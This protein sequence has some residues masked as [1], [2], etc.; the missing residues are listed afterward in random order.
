MYNV[1]GCFHR[2]RL[3]TEQFGDS[4]ITTDFTNG[5]K[6]C[7][8]GE[9]ITNGSIPCVSRPKVLRENVRENKKIPLYHPA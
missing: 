5:D 1:T 7:I 2:W 3:F 4:W 6:S 9:E 8:T